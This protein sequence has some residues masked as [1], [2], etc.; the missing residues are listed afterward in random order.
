MFVP[1]IPR[2]QFVIELLEIRQSGQR[3]SQKEWAE[4]YQRQD[5]YMV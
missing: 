3:L 5:Q 4:F 1:G 2:E